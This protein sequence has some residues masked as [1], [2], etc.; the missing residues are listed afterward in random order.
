M[1]KKIKSSAGEKI[2]ER[3]FHT[4]VFQRLFFKS[5]Y[6]FLGSVF[7]VNLFAYLANSLSLGSEV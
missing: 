3:K 1:Y 4:G 2:D 5:Y 7:N 6:N